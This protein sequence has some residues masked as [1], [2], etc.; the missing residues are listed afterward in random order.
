MAGFESMLI[1]HNPKIRLGHLL[2]AYRPHSW[3]GN[4]LYAIRRMLSNLTGVLVVLRKYSGP[5]ST[6][7]ASM[8]S[9]TLRTDIELH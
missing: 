1:P 6:A 4:W 3:V 8:R 7:I 9:T 5:H 2:F